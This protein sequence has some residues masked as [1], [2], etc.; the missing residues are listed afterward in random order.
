MQRQKKGGPQNRG[1]T[2]KSPSPKRAPFTPG[3]AWTPA[4]DRELVR[5][6]G[7]P[8]PLSCVQSFL[9]E[10]RSDIDLEGEARQSYVPPPPECL[11]AL[12]SGAQQWGQLV[13]PPGVFAR[14]S[15]LRL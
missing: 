12:R 10:K 1:R 4:R 3:L 8:K 15:S 2:N 14:A 11:V 13:S 9:F 7:V 6:A 5:G